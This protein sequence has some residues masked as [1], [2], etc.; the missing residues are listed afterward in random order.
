MLMIIGIRPKAWQLRN[1]RCE[2]QFYILPT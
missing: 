2:H 1:T